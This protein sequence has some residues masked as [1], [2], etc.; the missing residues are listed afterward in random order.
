MACT[1]PP[2]S[3]ASCCVTSRRPSKGISG[4][5]RADEQRIVQRAPVDGEGAGFAASFSLRPLEL[6]S[7]GANLFWRG[8]NVSLEREPAAGETGERHADQPANKAAMK[9]V[10]RVL[11]FARAA[12]DPACAAR[13]FIGRGQI[14]LGERLAGAQQ[15]EHGLAQLHARGPGLVHAGAGEHVGRAGALADAR[16]AVAVRNGSPCLPDSSS[17]FAPQERS[18]PSLR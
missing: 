17:D 13:V 11:G 6:G 3:S 5:P 12:L 16:K 1:L 9:A 4:Q 8:R 2:I 10:A 18:V 15:L 14:L 7:E